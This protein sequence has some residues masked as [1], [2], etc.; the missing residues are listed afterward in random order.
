MLK[1]KKDYVLKKMGD[2]F[3]VVTVGEASKEFNGMIR[4]N[5]PSAFVWEQMEKGIEKE[6]LLKLMLY[7]FEDLDEET[8]REDLESFLDKIAVAIEES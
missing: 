7:K 8:A 6:D 1:I 5:K 2:G 3:V 4:L